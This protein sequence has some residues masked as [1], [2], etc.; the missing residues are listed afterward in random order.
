MLQAAGLEAP[1]DLADQ[2]LL[3]AVGLDDGESA[4]DRHWVPFD[5]VWIPAEKRCKTAS[6]GHNLRRLNGERNGLS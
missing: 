6:C 4:F 2:V 5:S 1:V 3:D